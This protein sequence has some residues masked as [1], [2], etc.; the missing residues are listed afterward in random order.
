MSPS[1]ASGWLGSTLRLSRL[2]T[3]KKVGASKA[4]IR[5]HLIERAAFDESASR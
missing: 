4:A 2:L 5:R 3:R 1:W